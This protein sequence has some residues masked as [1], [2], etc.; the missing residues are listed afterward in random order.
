MDMNKTSVVDITPRML[1]CDQLRIY[2]NLG[3]NKAMEFAKQIGAVQ[4][5]GRRT[6]YDKK[7]IDEYFDHKSDIEGNEDNDASI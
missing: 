4:K 3:R 6:L 7:V 5:V 2:T 1:N